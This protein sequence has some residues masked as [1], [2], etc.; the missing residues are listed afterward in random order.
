MLFQFPT[1]NMNSGKGIPRRALEILT[2]MYNSAALLPGKA[3][4]EKQFFFFF[5]KIQPRDIE[6]I[7]EGERAA[8]FCCWNFFG[9]L[10]MHC[11]QVIHLKLA[12][13]RGF[14]GHALRNAR[15]P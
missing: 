1:E 10:R 15:K 6:H 14:M 13:K 12:R 7:F 11:L 9:P 8:K 5:W 3:E 2:F 4:V